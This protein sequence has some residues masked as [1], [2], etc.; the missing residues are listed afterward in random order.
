MST[1]SFSTFRAITGSVPF[2]CIIIFLV[3]SLVFFAWL[4]SEDPDFSMGHGRSFVFDGIASV[5]II[6]ILG[7]FAIFFSFGFTFT[8]P[9]SPIYSLVSRLV[10]LL[11][12]FTLFTL[13]CSNDLNIRLQA[14]MISPTNIM[15]VEVLLLIL[16]AFLQHSFVVTSLLFVDLN[17]NFFIMLNADNAIAE[18]CMNKRFDEP[19]ISFLILFLFGVAFAVTLLVPFHTSIS[20]WMLVLGD[21]LLCKIITAAMHVGAIHYIVTYLTCCLIMFVFVFKFCLLMRY[22]YEY[23]YLT[24]AIWWLPPLYEVFYHAQT[25]GLSSTL[26][27][28]SMTD[29]NMLLCSILFTSICLVCCVLLLAISKQDRTAKFI[30]FCALLCSAVALLGVSVIFGNGLT[31]L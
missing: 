25:V 12:V 11:V 5:I 28:F 21:D 16:I 9:Y 4:I 23:N 7:L 10:L 29:T 2:W 24:T 15:C 19:A 8:E 13:L 1:N 27:F 17:L 22:M 6:A 26:L 3:I 30:I 31:L 20:G 14:K 18:R